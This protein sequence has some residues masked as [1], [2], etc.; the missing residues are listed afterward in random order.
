MSITLTELQYQISRQLLG[1]DAPAEVTALAASGSW[2][3]SQVAAALTAWE[4][5]G[6]VI[7]EQEIRDEIDPAE[8]LG[9]LLAVGLPERRMLTLLRD[10]D[11]VPMKEATELARIHDLPFNEIIKWGSQRGWLLKDKGTL[12]LTD[13]GRAAI[14]RRDDDERALASA[15]AQ[16]PFF[17][18]QAAAQGLDA[19]RI[20]L[21]IKNRPQVAKLRQ[22]AIRRATLTDAGRALFAGNIEVLRVQNRLSSEDITSGAW[23]KIQIREYDVTLPSRN[24]YPARIH[25]LQKILEEVRQ[26]FLQMGFT[27]AVS[28]QVESAFWD[29][30]ALFQPQDHPARDMQDTFYVQRPN[31][32]KLPDPELVE[33]VRRT[34]EDGWET[35]SVGWGYRWNPERAKQVVM[36]THTTATSIRSL[37]AHPEP[38]LKSFCVGRVFRNEAISYKHLPQFHQVDGVIID[39]SASLGSLIGTLTEFY[40]IMG[41]TNIKI[42]PA[43]F[44][45]TEPSA[46]VFARAGSKGGWME[47][48][49]SGVFRPEV[50]RPFGCRY[51]VLAWGGGLERLAMHRFGLSDIREL[52]WA[53]LDKLQEVPQCR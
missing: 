29:F 9:L 21:L 48:C 30:D 3:Q 36:R 17:L 32:A 15:L 44:P 35:G 51:P 38:P 26:A 8:G 42:K 46:E 47:L 34:H 39:T 53:D 4:T 33:R 27:E 14:E 13:A 49:G 45:Y 18:D 25:P 37:A 50:T 24:V 6:L 1:A 19:E 40:R 31:V 28:P 16:P 20:R 11:A 5:E 10:M 22:R 52:Y 43:F 41:I 7:I 2:D 23:R 12:A